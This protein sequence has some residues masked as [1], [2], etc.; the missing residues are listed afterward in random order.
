MSDTE[1]ESAPA[2]AN[3]KFANVTLSE[4]IVRG[5]I[6]ITEL[7]LRKPKAGELR[8]LSLQDIIGTDVT[9]L[10]T[11]IPRISSPI[12]HPDEAENLD[13]DDLT[14]CGGAIRGFF[15][16]KAERQILEMM[17]AQANGEKPPT[18]Q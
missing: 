10:I 3:T 7:T 14:E 11:L 16:T 8:G 5:D 17:V 1:V 15:M 13:A 2:A 12:V 18:I 6:T 9:A 4:P